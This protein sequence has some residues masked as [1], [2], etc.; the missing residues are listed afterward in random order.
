MIFLIF[1]A[2]SQMPDANGVAE[3]EMP[4]PPRPVDSLKV[5]DTPND[6]GKSLDLAWQLSADTVRIAKYVVLRAESP[7]GPFTEIVQLM[8][9]TDY[10]T[11]QDTLLENKKDYYY[12]VDV[13]DTAGLVASSEITGPVRPMA[14]W[15]NT[16]RIPILVVTV[17]YSI[18]VILYIE[19]AKRDTGK[20]FVRRI[21]G[22]DAIDEAVGRSTEMGKPILFTFGIG[23]LTDIATI[24]AL[25][26]L[27]RIAK[28]SAEYETR[29]IVPNYDPVVMAAAQETV[30]Q[31]FVEAG[32]PDLYNDSD[33]TFLTSDQFGYAAGVDGIITREKPGTIFLQGIFYAESLILAETG[34]NIGA[35]QIAGTVMPEQLPFF[36]AACDY[37]LLGEELFAASAYIDRD[38]Q[39]L[40]SLKSEDM[41]KIVTVAIIAL[42][43][44]VGTVGFILASYVHGWEE[45][46]IVKLYQI[47]VNLFTSA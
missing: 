5:N 36:V 35:I 42:V 11:D 7:Q 31:G 4:V 29:L 20:M 30:K 3:A 25:S 33:I 1:L 46:I 44:L 13:V 26:I 19:L 9:P 38:P 39:L 23:Y 8:I 43:S 21:A 14:Q 22:L 40:G 10:Y 28:R 32:R 16:A 37:T 34:H 24:A 12:R 47:A 17:F 41:V 15:F 6:A 18:L 27:R 45:N 2:L